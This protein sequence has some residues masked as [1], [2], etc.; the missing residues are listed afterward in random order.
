MPQPS[1]VS[2]K[3][4]ITVLASSPCHMDSTIDYCASSL[5]QESQDEFVSNPKNSNAALAAEEKQDDY[6]SNTSPSLRRR[7]KERL[8]G[9]LILLSVY[10]KRVAS[11]SGNFPKGWREF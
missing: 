10:N 6:S 11:I 8:L 2:P 5:C 9:I 1:G 3:K 7:R 4:K